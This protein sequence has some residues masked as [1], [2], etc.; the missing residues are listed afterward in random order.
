M[1]DWTR[2]WLSSTVSVSG[3]SLLSIMLRKMGSVSMLRSSL[4]HRGTSAR[5]AE[6][7]ECT[8]QSSVSGSSGASGSGSESEEPKSSSSS[9]SMV[10]SSTG[11]VLPECAG[12]WRDEWNEGWTVW[13]IAA[14]SPACGQNWGRDTNPMVPCVSTKSHLSHR[15]VRLK[16]VLRCHQTQKPHK[17]PPVWKGLFVCPRP[18]PLLLHNHLSTPFFPNSILPTSLSAWDQHQGKRPHN[19]PETG[20]SHHTYSAD[21]DM[22]VPAQGHLGM[23]L[24][25]IL[26]DLAH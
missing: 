23:L 10:Y 12:E 25:L 5:W 18:A 13:R 14:D 24:C 22:A 9:A 6:V 15:A 21:V 8:E 26:I 7:P 3:S 4:T 1:G 19:P 20:H 11:L 17:N 16:D 2:L